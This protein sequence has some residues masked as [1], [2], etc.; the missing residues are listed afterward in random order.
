MSFRN[1][2]PATQTCPNCLTSHDVSVYVTGQKL[3]C[4][5]G[6]HFEVRRVDVSILSP[7]SALEA[8]LSVPEVGFEPTVTPPNRGQG[9][10]DDHRPFNTAVAPIE[11]I[12]IPG[13]ELLEV[14]GRGGMGEV[15]KA[16]QKSL[17]R[18]VAVKVLPSR[19]AKDAEF[20]V[21]FEKEATALASLNHP[22]IVQIIDRGVVSEHYFFAMEF[23][24]GKSLRALMTEGITHPDQALRMILQVLTAMDYAHRKNIVHRDLK[25]ENI[26]LGE[27]GHIKIADF[28]LV[29]IRGEKPHVQLTATSVAMGTVNYM[30]PE[31]RRDAKNVDARADIFSVGVILYEL[32]TGELPLGRFRMPS[33]KMRGVDV[34]LDAILHRALETEVQ[35]RYASAQEMLTDLQAL[36]APTVPSRM[37]LSALKDNAHSFQGGGRKLTLA[38]AVLATSMGIWLSARTVHE[39]KYEQ[40]SVPPPVN[41]DAELFISTKE[42]L[43]EN[44][45]TE[46]RFAFVDGEEELNAH[47]GKWWLEEGCL[48]AIQFGREISEKDLKLVPRTYVAQRYFSSDDFLAEVDMQVSRL[49]ERYGVEANAQ[50]FSEMSLRIKDLQVSIFAIPN[51]GMRLG[52]KYFTPDGV[53]IAGNSSRDLETLVEDEM[54]VP[55]GKFRVKL[56]MKKVN[57]AVDVEAFVNDKRFARK[58]LVGL[59]GQTGKLALGCRNLDCQFSALRVRGHIQPRPVT[60]AP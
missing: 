22:N 57:Q 40:E 28:G 39:R 51:A 14:L 48:K 37:A 59:Q 10:S 21:R 19:L 53:E 13:Y 8:K 3:L 34:R 17:G 25:P 44:G 29:G 42:G 20:V 31:Q 54:P 55:K 27:G 5:C 32:L 6:I 35:D 43:A 45:M 11:R 23:V 58:V 26:L 38:V 46:L 50:R 12:E 47:A 60:R 52:W 41:T 15:W 16:H 24:E 18:L 49:E 7:A 56:Q 4:R 30:A 2:K 9:K 1:S 33:E 36:T